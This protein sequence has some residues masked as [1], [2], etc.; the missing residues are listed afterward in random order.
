LVVIM[1]LTPVPRHGY[2]VGLPRPGEWREVLNSDAG[3]YGGSNVGN[4]GGVTA[5][6]YNMHNQSYS[7]RF[8]LP[9]LGVLIFQPVR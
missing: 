5:E 1:N 6:D 2:R 9:P 3:L 7:G 8:T 4:F